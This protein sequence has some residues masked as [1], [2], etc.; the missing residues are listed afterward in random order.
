MYKFPYKPKAINHTIEQ[1]TINL[2]LY[3]GI[4]DNMKNN[5]S[6]LL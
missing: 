3:F 6:V 4:L 5:C 2:S 1:N